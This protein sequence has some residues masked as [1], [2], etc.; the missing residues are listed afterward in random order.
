MRCRVC[1]ATSSWRGLSPTTARIPSR[2]GL[3]AQLSQ[4]VRTLLRSGI[5]KRSGP[6]SRGAE[7]R[8]AKPCGAEPRGAEPW[9]STS[10]SASASASTRRTFPVSHFTGL[11]PNGVVTLSRNC[12]NSRFTKNSRN[13]NNPCSTK[14]S[15]KSNNSCSANSVNSVNAIDPGPSPAQ[16]RKFARDRRTDPR[17]RRHVEEQR[18]PGANAV[19]VFTANELRDAAVHQRRRQHHRHHLRARA[20]AAPA[21]LRG[22]A[23][24]QQRPARR[25]ANLDLHRVPGW[26]HRRNSH[27]ALQ[28]R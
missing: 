13:A 28:Q 2:R 11:H 16:L 7:P 10:A 5:P 18:V 15:R 9:N 23:D 20:A 8:C 14:N 25:P 3:D 6:N 24:H 21:R 4:G 27:T 22:V 1:C 19:H 17:Q 26:S 12:N